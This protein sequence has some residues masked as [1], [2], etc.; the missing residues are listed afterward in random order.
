MLLHF[1]MS[2]IAPTFDRQD[3]SQCFLSE[4]LDTALATALFHEVR[5]STSAI[6][7]IAHAF[8]IAYGT[9]TLL[10]NLKH[11]NVLAAQSMYV[12][13]YLMSTYNPQDKFSRAM[14]LLGGTFDCEVTEKL[15]HLVQTPPSDITDEKKKALRKDILRTATQK[16]TRALKEC[17]AI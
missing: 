8:E 1:G 13:Q 12:Y 5:I 10:W 16:F 3:L 11:R 17:E 2:S 9:T 4:Y 7:N 15:V 14:S 6:E